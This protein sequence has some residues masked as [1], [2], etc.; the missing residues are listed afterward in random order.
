MEK[1]LTC[2][3]LLE[4]AKDEWKA[5]K[6]YSEMPEPLKSFALD[7]LKHFSHAAIQLKEKCPTQAKEIEAL[8]REK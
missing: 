2:S 5:F 1:E 6:D 3:T 8:I 4:L 7:E